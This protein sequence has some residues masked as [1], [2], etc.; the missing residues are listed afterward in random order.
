M[1]ALSSTLYTNQSTKHMS[2][3]SHG[4]AADLK[5]MQAVIAIPASGAGTALND[6]INAF[7]LPKGAIPRSLS[8]KTDRLDTDASPLLSFDLGDGTTAQKFVAAWLGAKN[9]VTAVSPNTVDALIGTIGV[10][11]TVDTPVVVTVH[12]AAATAAAG[13][14][15]VS[16]FY[17]MGG[18]AS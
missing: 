17:E 2:K 13:T 11:L 1:A 3:F 15:I 8:I 14:M 18:L 10:Q 7:I 12:A 6:T 9:V 5:I 16:C 4:L